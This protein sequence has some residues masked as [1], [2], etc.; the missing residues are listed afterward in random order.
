MKKV[1]PTLFGIIVLTVLSFLAISHSTYIKAAATH[2]VISQIQAAGSGSGNA[3]QEFVELFNPTASSIDIT[4]WRLKE[5]N[6][7]NSSSSNLVASMSGVISSHGYFLVG[8]P[9]YP[10]SPAADEIYSASS[11]AFTANSTIVLFSDAGTTIVDKV[12]MGTAVD[13]ET[14]TAPAP[15]PS[16]SI[17]RKLDE[18]AGHGTDTDDNSADFESVAVSAPRNSLTIIATATPTE[19][20]TST[21]TPSPTN[22][23]AATPT[24]TPSPSPTPTEVP[25]ATPT[26]TPTASPTATSTPTTT[27]TQTPT[28]TPTATPTSSPTNTPT[29]TPSTNPTATPTSFPFPF[30]PLVFSCHINY[31]T[32][33]TGW[34]ILSLPQIFCGFNL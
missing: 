10:G 30:R 32:I 16:G 28:Q 14:N 13:K 11:S 21:P 4:G 24:L 33:N 2:I 7:T 23:P 1:L 29:A 34:F 20:P 6:P 25:T 15:T 8:S 3:D 5:E 22:T 9:T 12:G 18:N 26:A 17:Q 31:I 27:P 19:T